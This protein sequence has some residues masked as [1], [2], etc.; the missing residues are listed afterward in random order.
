MSQDT[1]P[2]VRVV[3]T[4]TRIRPICSGKTN[5]PAFVLCLWVSKAILGTVAREEHRKEFSLRPLQAEPTRGIPDLGK[6]GGLSFGFPYSTNPARPQH[7][8]HPRGEGVHLPRKRKQEVAPTACGAQPGGHSGAPS[9]CFCTGLWDCCC[10]FRLLTPEDPSGT[11][12]HVKVLK[13]SLVSRE[14]PGL[15]LKLIYQLSE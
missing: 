7:A 14:N 3:S 5:L 15:Y 13:Y 1:E 6:L 10:R 8:A 2:A 4:R 12:L 11:P 9:S